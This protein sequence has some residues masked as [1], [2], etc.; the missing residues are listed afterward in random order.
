[1]SAI[2]ATLEVETSFESSSTGKVVISKNINKI[3]T[4]KAGVIVHIIR[5]LTYHILGPGFNP[6][7]HTQ[8]RRKYDEGINKWY[9][10]IEL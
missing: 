7:C 1:M 9:R 4:K 3:K 2:P 6:L 5:D 8:K 10:T